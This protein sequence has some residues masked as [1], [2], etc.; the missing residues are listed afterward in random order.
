MQVSDPHMPRVQLASMH[1]F[2][3]CEGTH[4]CILSLSFIIS[5]PTRRGQRSVSP[6]IPLTP[7]L[8]TEEQ[9]S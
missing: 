8:T 1:V 4:A 2:F 5:V 9:D 3:G 6:P 7:A